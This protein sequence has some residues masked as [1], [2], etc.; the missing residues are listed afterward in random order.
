MKRDTAITP[1]V[2]APTMMR[3]QNTG[4]NAIE[5]PFDEIN[6]YS[7]VNISLEIKNSSAWFTD[8]TVGHHD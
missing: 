6:I 5:T 7:N 1:D 4:G 2:D 8:S 3:K